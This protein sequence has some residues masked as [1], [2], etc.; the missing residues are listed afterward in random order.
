MMPA[1]FL[2]NY[3]KH[4]RWAET[5]VPPIETHQ[6]TRKAY[7]IEVVAKALGFIAMSFIVREEGPKWIYG[8]KNIENYPGFVKCFLF[9]FILSW[10]GGP[11]TQMI[12]WRLA[13][14]DLQQ[15]TRT[16]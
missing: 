12:R 14:S 8:T 10:L 3:L 4:K 9:M 13:P 15:R 6:L 5:G 2:M 16:D 11:Y 1:H 7:W